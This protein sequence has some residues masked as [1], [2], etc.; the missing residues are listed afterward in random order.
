MPRAKWGVLLINGLSIQAVYSGSHAIIK[1]AFNY[2]YV[3]LLCFLF[4]SCRDKQSSLVRSADNMF[5]TNE[6]TSLFQSKP[7]VI[8]TLSSDSAF[9]RSAVVAVGKVRYIDST[10]HNGENAY[11]YLL[12]VTVDSVL[13]GKMG[14]FNKTYLVARDPP[15]IR[16]GTDTQ[17]T[18]YL[19]PLDKRLKLIS[20]DIRWQW[21]TQAPAHAY[22]APAIDTMAVVRRHVL[23]HYRRRKPRIH[24]IN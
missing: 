4:V 21:T 7:E 16:A 20:N 13:K 15:P 3:L 6:D 12:C 23:R 8:T 14:C 1:R 11:F 19:S 24:A 2:R 18:I 17:W 5:A 10:M 9:K 22:T